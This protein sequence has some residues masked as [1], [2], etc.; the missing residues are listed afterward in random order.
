[1]LAVEG[2][3]SITCHIHSEMLHICR[4]GVTFDQS[5]TGTEKTIRNYVTRITPT[6][7]SVTK[8]KSSNPKN[9]AKAIPPLRNLCNSI[10]PPKIH[11]T[12]QLHMHAIE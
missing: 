5:V 4:R 7:V 1:M 10:T 6:K 12:F 8:C 2:A 3:K 11:V 9:T